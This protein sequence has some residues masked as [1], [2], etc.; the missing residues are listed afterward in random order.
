MKKR[1]V[2]EDLKQFELFAHLTDKKLK[3]L[4][5]LIYWRTYKKGQFLFLEGDSRERIYLVLDGFIKLER[6]NQ[7]GNLLYEEYIKRFSIFPYGDMFTDKAYDYTAVAMTDVDVYY[8][9][10]VIFENMIRSSRKQLIYIVQQ[11]SSILK[12]TESRV[13]N[14]SI[15][16]AQDRVIQALHHLMNFLGEQEGEEIIISCPFTTTEIS[17]ISGTCRETVS[18]VLKQLKN[19]SIITVLGKKIIIHDPTYFK[20]VSI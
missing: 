20:E 6:V 2:V 12:V 8:I 11:L 17:K 5:E 18:G 10:T 3:S 19:E 1:N 9:P 16:N 14:I 4:A 15:P 7:S 13:Q